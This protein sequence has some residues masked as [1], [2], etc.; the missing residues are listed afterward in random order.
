MKGEDLFIALGKINDKYIESSEPKKIPLY[1]RNTFRWVTVTAACICLFVSGYLVSTHM[2][3]EKL[4]ILN[5]YSIIFEPMGMG[6]EGT[7]ELSL[8]NS[9]DINPWNEN[10]TL[11]TLPVYKNLRYNDGKLWQ[12]YYSANELKNQT[13]AFAYL[14]GLDVL[15][16]EAVLG[17]NEKEVY[18]YVLNTAQGTVSTSGTGISLNL[19][20][21]NENLLN[22]HMSY[23]FADET[24]KVSGTCREYSIDGELLSSEKRSYYKYGDIT[25][26]IIS[27]NMQSYWQYE[28]DAEYINSRNDDYLSCGEKLGDYP[29]I[30]VDEAKEKLIDGEYVSSADEESVEGGII[31]ENVIAK[32]DLIYYTA[33]NQQLYMPYYRFYVKYYSGSNEI[34]QYAYFYVCA[35]EDAYLSGNKKI[36]GSFQ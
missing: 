13:E 18:A 4:P 21:G 19:K 27:F 34:Q 23:C 9:D 6:Y 25:D 30:N 36:G 3:A 28:N 17:E 35:I 31:T 22:K 10:V 5:N 2:K 7:D 8:K 20:K 29:V 1:K 32:T 14:M 11:K 12:N 16:G 33:G 24:E 15:G 26:N